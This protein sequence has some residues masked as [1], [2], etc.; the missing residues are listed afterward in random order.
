MRNAYR[1]AVI[2]VFVVLFI[3]VSD[4]VAAQSINRNLIDGLNLQLFYVALPLAILVE[5]IL[6][7]AVWRYH[8]N[9]SPT[10][11][12][13]NLPLEVSW[14]IAVAVILLFVGVAA[15]N[16]MGSPY[17][18]PPASPNTTYVH[19][20]EEPHL[21]GAI[22]PDDPNA[23]VVDVVAY[24]WGWSI[25]YPGRNV[26]LRNEMVI[27]ANTNVYMHLTSRDVV[28]AFYAP[29]LGLKQDTY[30]GSWNT[31][32]TNVSE[33]G[34]YRVYCSEYCGAGHSRMYANLTVVSS[35]AYQ[36]WLAERSK[37]TGS[38]ASARNASAATAAGSLHAGTASDDVIRR[39]RA[40]ALSAGG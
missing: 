29:T 34:S 25:D 38:V 36:R 23:I 33:T 35:E 9:D 21:Y 14:T 22:E 4:P 32:R 1:G 40:R 27:P 13:D 5:T 16:V 15:F 37:G 7:Y 10:P 28:H 12:E 31:I 6:F 3:L 19:A 20:E 11:T 2:S 30:P 24:Q 39:V 17:M 8:G 26:S 18:T